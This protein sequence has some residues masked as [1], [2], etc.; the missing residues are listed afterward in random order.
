MVVQLPVTELRSHNFYIINTQLN[1]FQRRLLMHDTVNPNI[2]STLW[3]DF[4]GFAQVI[5]SLPTY[6]WGNFARIVFKHTVYTE[7]C[8]WLNVHQ[9][10]KI[11]RKNELIHTSTSQTA[12]LPPCNKRYKME[13][14]CLRAK[15]NLWSFAYSKVHY[16]PVWK[17]YNFLSN[18]HYRRFLRPACASLSL[19]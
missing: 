11:A 10:K 2:H 9:S 4:S 1:V 7:G 8:K 19:C 16:G 13:S 18:I 17:L 3:D 12:I 5:N 14:Y 6:R 15:I